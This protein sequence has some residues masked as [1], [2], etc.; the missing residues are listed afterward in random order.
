MDF[1]VKTGGYIIT[2][3]STYNSVTFLKYFASL[4]AFLKKSIRPM[5]I[6]V[7]L[8]SYMLKTR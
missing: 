4:K 6:L 5:Y 3:L 2:A 7:W 8:T 1:C